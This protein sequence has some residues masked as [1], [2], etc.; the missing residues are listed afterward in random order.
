MTEPSENRILTFLVGLLGL[1]LAVGFIWFTV[2]MVLESE[3]A[4]DLE[5][6]K[7][8][9]CLKAGGL[10]ID[11]RHTDSYCYQPKK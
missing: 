1:A 9:A 2:W 4:K 6:K 11:N 7:H 10:W 5:Q 8:D 3:H